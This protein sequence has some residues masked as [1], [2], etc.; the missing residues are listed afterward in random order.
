MSPPPLAFDPYVEG[1]PTRQALDQIGNRWTILVIGCLAEGP[2]R[3]SELSRRVPGISAKMLTQTLRGLERDG[4]VTRTVHPVVP[5]HVEYEI[6][7]LGQTVEEPVAAL[8]RWA[9]DHMGDVLAARDRYDA[10]P[11]PALTGSAP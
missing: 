8:Q 6:T 11:S 4:L 10:R 2:A 5:P 9:V 7:E 1:C 3:Y